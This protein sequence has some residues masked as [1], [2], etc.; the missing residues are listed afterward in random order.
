MN[1][2]AVIKKYRRP[3][4]KKINLLSLFL[5]PLLITLGCWQLQRA[6]QKSRLEA[7]WQE[8]QRQ[9]IIELH[10][11]NIAQLVDHQRVMVE[12]KFL[13]DSYWLLDNRHRQ[14]HYGFEVIQIFV[15]GDGQRLLINRGWI[16][17]NARRNELPRVTTPPGPLTLFGELM[18]IRKNRL[19][20]PD[21]LTSTDRPEVIL[22]I[23]SQTLA[24]KTQQPLPDRYLRLDSLSEAALVTDWPLSAMSSARHRGYAV[25][26]FGLAA[27]LL[28]GCLLVNSG[29]WQ[30]QQKKSPTEEKSSWT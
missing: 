27:V 22:A 30:G 23:D 16:K 2:P 24:K 15:T 29:R 19:V 6:E 4:H 7:Q 17:A 11:H 25:Q 3:V 21:E 14:G 26:W 9:P 1:K 12:G 5:L 18:S 28:A 8:Q 10:P 20:S 13:S